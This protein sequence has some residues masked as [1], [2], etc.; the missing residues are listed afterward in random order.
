[1]SEQVLKAKPESA[2]KRHKVSLGVC[3]ACKD[4][5]FDSKEERKDIRAWKDLKGV[6]EKWMGLDPYGSIYQETY[7]ES[8]PEGH[9][10]HKTCRLK[11]GD[12]KRLESALLRKRQQEE[13]PERAQS[14]DF[15][16]GSEFPANISS[17]HRRKTSNLHL[18]EQK[19]TWMKLKSAT[20]FLKDGIVRERILHFLRECEDPFAREVRYHK[21]CWNQHIRYGR[22]DEGTLHVQRVRKEEFNQL[23]FEHV[24]ECVIRD[25][26][27]RTLKGLMK[28]YN[29][30]LDN[31][32]YPECERTSYI[33][34]ILEDAFGD[35]LGFHSRFQKN[36]STIVYDSKSGGTYIEAAINS[37]GIDKEHL[38]NNVARHLRDTLKNH[39]M[40]QWPPHSDRLKE[41]KQPP[42]ELRHFLTW[43]HDPSTRDFAD[44]CEDPIIAALNSASCNSSQTNKKQRAHHALENVHEGEEN[45]VCPEQL[46]PGVPGVA[47]FDNDDFKE[48]TRD[49]LK[50]LIPSKEAIRLLP[51]GQHTIAGYKTKKRGNPGPIAQFDVSLKEGTMCQKLRGFTHALVHLHPNLEPV[52]PE[53]QNNGAYSGF[54]ASILDPICKS[55]AYFHLTLP[56]PPNKS[57]VNEVIKRCVRA[58]E[59]KRMPFIQL[60]GDQPVYALTKEVKSENP[61]EFKLVLPILGGFHIQVTFLRTIFSRFN[62]SGLAPLAVASGIISAGS[63]EQAL[64][65]SPEV[66]LALFNVNST[67][68]KTVKVRLVDVLVLEDVKK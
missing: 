15:M 64:K 21:S 6:A 7:W 33:K 10:I 18:L 57:V 19:S 48:D 34:K 25:K 4:D 68:R 45:P 55:K 63:V 3:L 22:Q 8:G 62:G 47:A 58:A 30:L 12:S 27:P 41:E 35:E 16:P 17:V 56:K 31:F 66:P 43:L 26:E 9:F 1:M 51:K 36:E 67:L 65:G 52:T 42:E 13:S 60:T 5:C 49:G 28:D 2:A 40:Q 29:K 53:K 39:P 24:R 20:I 23:F 37:W 54:Y 32:N 44:D 38:L 11:L 46:A 59:D 61:E 50:L 14:N